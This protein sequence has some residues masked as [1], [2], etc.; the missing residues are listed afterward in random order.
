MAFVKIGLGDTE[1][2]AASPDID[3]AAYR[4]QG[5]YKFAEP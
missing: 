3:P 2:T 5:I 1:S 4:L